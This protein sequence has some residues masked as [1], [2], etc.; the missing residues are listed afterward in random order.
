MDGWLNPQMTQFYFRLNH[1]LCH[2]N[3]NIIRDDRC[4]SGSGSVRTYDGWTLHSHLDLTALSFLIQ[5]EGGNY[6]FY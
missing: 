6:P 2:V 3:K 5:D 1:F 4:V